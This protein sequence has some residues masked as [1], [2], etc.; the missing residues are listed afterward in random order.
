[1]MF[2]VFFGLVNLG[3]WVWLLA[4]I[5]GTGD[6][7]DGETGEMLEACEAG[8]AVGGF[9]S[10]AL[11][12]FLWVAVDVILYVGYRIFRRKPREA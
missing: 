3:F 10:A 11:I 2:R 7:C 8:A 9:A 4:A 1:M 5:A 12:L 6:V